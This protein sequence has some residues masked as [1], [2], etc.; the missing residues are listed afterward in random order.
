MRGCDIE[1]LFA[2]EEIIRVEIAADEVGVGDGR[3]RAAAAVAGRAG[4]GAGALRADIEEAA[5]VDPGDRAAAR[6][7]RGHVERRHVDLAAR[8]HAFGRFQRHAAFDEGD[9]G[10]GAAHVERDEA[11][12]R[13]ILG[14]IGARLRAGGRVRKTACAPC[15]RRRSRRENGITPP[16]DCIRK[17]CWVSTPARS[18][19]VLRWSM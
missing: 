12:A 15:A 6:R 1:L 19:P 4:I 16:F 8:D 13:V 17:R 3:A 10:A 5:A 7:D 2:A 14:E 9:V 18:R 11:A